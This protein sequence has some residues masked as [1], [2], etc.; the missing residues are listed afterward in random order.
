M[1]WVVTELELISSEVLAAL[2]MRGVPNLP[3]MGQLSHVGHDCWRR[4]GLTETEMRVDSGRASV[5][6]GSGAVGSRSWRPDGGTRA[7]ISVTNGTY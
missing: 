7:S 2:D 4:G 3:G 5:G 6:A 1:R